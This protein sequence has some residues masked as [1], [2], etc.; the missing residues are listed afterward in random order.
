MRRIAWLF[1]AS[2]VVGSSAPAKS[3]PTPEDLQLAA[4]EAFIDAYYS[5]DPEALRSA[6][7]SAPESSVELLYYQ[8][9]A[10]GGNYKVLDR[11]PCRVDKP[12]EVSCAIKVKDDLIGALGTGYDVTDVFHFAFRD[13]RVVKVW[14]SSDDPPEFKAAMDWLRK[15]RPA[16]FTGPCH[17][18]YKGGTTPGD[19]V[20]AV[21]KGFAEHRSLSENQEATRVDSA[22]ARQ[23]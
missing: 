3:P 2:L 18:M 15:E 8:G 12:D 6:L 4:A 10:Q 14:N 7:A 21:V 19:C 1:A 17:L 9:W 16:I 20:Q 23:E 13:G 5:F 22:P 11:K